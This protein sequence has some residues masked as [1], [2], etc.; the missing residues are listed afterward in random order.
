M[1]EFDWKAFVLISG[2]AIVCIIYVYIKTSF[3]ITFNILKIN[4]N[5][6]QLKSR[7]TWYQKEFKIDM[8]LFVQFKWELNLLFYGL[9]LCDKVMN[10]KN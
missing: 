2:I 3:I 9:F 6:F 8:I 10:G 5:Y 4:Q 7:K 1:S